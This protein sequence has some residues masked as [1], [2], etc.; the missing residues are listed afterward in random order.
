MRTEND[1]SVAKWINAGFGLLGLGLVAGGH[2]LGDRFDVPTFVFWVGGAALLC[3]A[4]VFQL[5]LYRAPPV[6]VTPQ[7]AAELQHRTLRNMT[8]SAVGT[9]I[10]VAGGALVWAQPSIA[11]F[12]IGAVLMVVG[13]ITG[14]VSGLPLLRAARLSRVDPSLEDERAQANQA[15]SY[16]NAYLVGLQAAVA[17]ALLSSWN[18]IVLEAS[19]LGFIVTAAMVLAQ[20]TTLA[21]REWSD[22]AA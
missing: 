11:V 18:M 8:L 20:V 6:Q 17:L 12:A 4:L 21:W 15:I 22:D 3:T 5:V 7:D 13:V 16:R 1:W 19:T 10:Y 14:L 2:W 9:W